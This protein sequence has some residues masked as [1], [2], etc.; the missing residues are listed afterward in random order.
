MKFVNRKEAPVKVQVDSKDSPKIWVTLKKGEFV[1]SEDKDYAKHYTERGLTK[2]VEGEKIDVKA[3]VI[4]KK[5]EIKPA[6]DD[7]GKDENKEE[8]KKW[9]G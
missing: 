9:S 4:P 2:D 5:K 3:K 1:E 7:L 6:T 8:K